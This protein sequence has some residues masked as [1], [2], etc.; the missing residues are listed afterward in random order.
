MATRNQI[1]SPLSGQSGTGSFV[2]SISPSLTTPALGVAAAT[3]VNFGVDP[4]S[5]F[6]SL[7]AWTPTATFAVPGDLSVSYSV[8]GG[9]YSRIGNIVFANFSMTF[10]PTFTT[11][12]G[13]FSL[14]GLPITSNSSTDNASQGSFFANA[15]VFTATYTSF[16]C[17]VGAGSSAIF[18]RLS[19]TAAASILLS[20]TGFVSGAAV[21]IRGAVLY[22]A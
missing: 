11:A 12:S 1:D 19:K 21:T 14:T 4:L 13:S 7:T 22:L 18:F 9:F 2:G 20:T 16:N 6:T 15:V 8:R 17:E 3:S 5:A 10:T